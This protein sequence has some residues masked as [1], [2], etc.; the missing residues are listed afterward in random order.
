MQ[1]REDLVVRLVNSEDFS[2][3][4]SSTELLRYMN[5]TGAVVRLAGSFHHVGIV[6]EYE[7]IDALIGWLDE[8]PEPVF[9][10]NHLAAAYPRAQKYADIASGLVAIALPRNPRDHML[11]FRRE[12]RATVRWAGDPSKPVGAGI[13]GERLTPRGSFAEWREVSRGWSAPWTDGDLEAAE[14]LRVVIL[15][16]VLRNVESARREREVAFRRQSLLLAAL[17]H[18][19]KNTLGKIDALITA[20]RSSATSVQ[21]FATNLQNRIKAMAQAHNL[22]AE[23]RWIGASMHKVAQ[24]ET[25]PFA[26]SGGSRISISGIELF[27]SPIEALALSMVLH[28]LVTNAVKHGALSTPPGR[29]ALSWGEDPELH[30]IWVR[31]EESGGPTVAAEV[32]PGLGLTLIDRTVTHE[33]HGSVELQFRPQ[34]FYCEIRIPAGN[35]ATR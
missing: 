18:R 8:T 28:E 20:S 10:T 16:H 11:W 12:I 14:R 13:H 19:V 6:P 31:W 9:A 35:P 34:G 1:T 22:L 29:A 4:L 26:E 15:E 30:Q 21:S 5:A 17:D 33:L 7:E 23:G 27:L 32:E 3:T 2:A 24:E 25:E